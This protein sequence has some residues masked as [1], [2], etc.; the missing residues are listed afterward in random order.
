MWIW[1]G[2]WAAP[3]LPWWLRGKESTTC[4]IIGSGR[5]PLNEE[6]A[7]QPSVLAWE[8]P[9]TEEPG[10][11]VHGAAESR[12]RLSE[13]T[14]GREEP[15]AA[16]HGAAESRTRLVTESHSAVHS[17]LSLGPCPLSTHGSL[18]LC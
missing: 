2:P 7:T 18:P 13:H 6:R 9:W 14:R 17:A 11:A 5:L 15:G 4:S 12:T 16:V 10:A 3:G 8:I 1:W